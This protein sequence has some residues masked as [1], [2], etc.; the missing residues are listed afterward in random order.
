MYPYVPIRK[1]IAE[2]DKLT[3]CI[4]TSIAADR[5]KNRIICS[6]DNLPALTE[7]LLRKRDRNK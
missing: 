4:L 3:L 2:S 5:F 1:N 7:R 6:S